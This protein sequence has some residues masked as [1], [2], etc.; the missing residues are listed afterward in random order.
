MDGQEALPPED[1]KLFQD[2]FQEVPLDEPTDKNAKKSAKTAPSTDILDGLVQQAGLQE[3]VPEPAPEPS[4]PSSDAPKAE[5]AS[6]GMIGTLPS[7]SDS[8]DSATILAA[9]E[10]EKTESQTKDEPQLDEDGDPVEED[11]NAQSEAKKPEYPD[12]AHIDAMPQVQL[13]PVRVLE[14]AL[15]LAN[16]PM[17]HKQLQD[18]LS[19]PRDR[20]D[21]LL[22]E[23]ARIV[24]K[25]SS[26]ELSVNEHGAALQLK[27]HYLHRVARLSKEVE[28]SKKSMRILALVA[29][30]KE[31]M[32]SDLKHFFKGEIYAYVTELKMAGYLESKKAG[33]TRR[34]KPTSKFYESFQIKEN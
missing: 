33:N 3:I 14:A 25:E 12:N 30:K 9:G 13:E 1:Q 20:L 6:A 11:G 22:G 26:F 23:L 8:S 10:A 17:S 5:G 28:L 27:P 15:F 16:K 32:Q 7:G 21:A 2:D 18:L 31:L 34:L 29:K 4:N 19:V 24:P